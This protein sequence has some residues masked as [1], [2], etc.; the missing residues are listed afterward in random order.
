MDERETPL[1]PNEYE[2]FFS[3]KEKS[4]NLV[5]RKHVD[6]V[7]DERMTSCSCCHQA[8]RKQTLFLQY[9][10]DLGSS[11]M[12][13]FIPHSKRRKQV[14]YL[15]WLICKSQRPIEF[16]HHYT[17]YLC[18]VCAQ[19]FQERKYLSSVCPYQ[20]IWNNLGVQ[21]CEDCHRPT[22]REI[23]RGFLT[24]IPP[25]NAM[26]LDTLKRMLPGSWAIYDGLEQNIFLPGGLY[27]FRS[28]PYQQE[29]KEA[30]HLLEKFLP[31]VLVLL[32]LEEFLSLHGIFW[33]QTCINTRRAKDELVPEFPIT[34]CNCLV[35]LPKWRGGIGCF[36]PMGTSFYLLWLWKPS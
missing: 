16:N 18:H 15:W 35:Q 24:C 27:V 26:S 3:Q 14:T 20:D 2:D 19:L 17:T 12:Y 31:L 4:S 10:N 34:C 8:F 13:R 33:C 11:F 21:S 36:Q 29:R 1:D 25:D 6:E 9:G 5:L 32:I 7:D 28:P 23:S 22:P 30:K